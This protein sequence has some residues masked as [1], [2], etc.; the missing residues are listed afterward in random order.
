MVFS[1]RE[2]PGPC[3]VTISAKRSYA[4]RWRGQSRSTHGRRNCTRRMRGWDG[5]QTAPTRLRLP[6]AQSH[7]NHDDAYY[8]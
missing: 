1:P 8:E 2:A 3:D 5:N 7:R 6:F 4:V